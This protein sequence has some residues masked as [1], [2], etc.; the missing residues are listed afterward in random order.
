[1]Y[2]CQTCV[3][4]P[5]SSCDGKPCTQCDP[6]SPFHN[7]YV[8]KEDYSTKER[9]DERLEMMHKLYPNAKPTNADRIRAMT[10][11]ELADAFRLE[12]CPKG[13]AISDCSCD[14]MREPYPNECKKCWLEWLKQEYEA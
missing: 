13:K 1:M 8:N 5:P 2:Y 12:G 14:L 10:D 9:M 3:Y 11:E 6:E 4:Y 7:C